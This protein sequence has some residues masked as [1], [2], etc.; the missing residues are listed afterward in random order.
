M[1]G[2][3]FDLIAQELLKQKQNMEQMEEANRELRRQLAELREG[4]G[5]FVEIDGR[6]FSLFSDGVASSQ[7]PAV[8]A[9][10]TAT[11]AP[12]TIELETQVEPVAVEHDVAF[13]KTEEL[14]MSVPETPRPSVDFFTDEKIA[15]QTTDPTFLE[16]VMINEFAS[17]A[18]SPLSVW[19]APKQEREK[20]STD[21]TSDQELATLRRQLIGSYLLE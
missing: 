10:P 3:N 13:D 4:R 14:V 12:V 15:A 6:R 16:E 2:S 11:A 20:T 19:S 8:E 18:T 17:A 21:V 5:I 9:M 7:A 1:S